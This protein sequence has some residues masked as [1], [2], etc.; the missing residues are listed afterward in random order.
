LIYVR[1]VTCIP[2]FMSTPLFSYIR[3][4]TRQYAP[5]PS[6]IY[7]LITISRT[8]NPY[9]QPQQIP[10]MYSQPASKTKRQPTIR[11]STYL[12]I[13]PQTPQ[14][15]HCHHYQRNPYAPVNAPPNLS[16]QILKSFPGIPERTCIHPP[17][18]LTQHQLHLHLSSLSLFSQS[19]H[20]VGQK[21]FG[22]LRMNLCF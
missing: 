21:V 12:F 3:S 19:M 20:A 9:F 18:A 11:P 16:K 13:H 14:T 22:V 5:L 1:K 6:Y 4:P 10:L 8:Y 7:N 17:Q 2:C 15:P